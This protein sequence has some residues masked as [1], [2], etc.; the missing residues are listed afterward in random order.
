MIILCLLNRLKQSYECKVVKPA[1]S[2]TG[3]EEGTD[4]LTC[5][6][7]LT[8]LCVLHNVRYWIKWWWKICNTG[9]LSM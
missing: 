3:L 2:V 6:T 1:Y 5:L 4:Y 7:D 9:T 8:C